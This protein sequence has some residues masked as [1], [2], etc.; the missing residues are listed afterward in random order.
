MK[1][2]LKKAV[3]LF[4]CMVFLLTVF[5]ACNNSSGDTETTVQ[6]D[7]PN[8]PVQV[9]SA[10]LSDYLIIYPENE[11]ST[12]LIEQIGNLKKLIQERYGVS[13][14]V[15]DDFV[16]EGS[17]YTVNAHEILIG[18]TNREESQAVCAEIKKAAD[19]E[20]RLCGE[21]PVIAGIT[22]GST[23]AAVKKFIEIIQNA[24]DSADVFFDGT[25][26]VSYVGTYELDDLTVGGASIAEY[27]IVYENNNG[28]KK[29]ANQIAEAVLDRTGYVLTMQSSVKAIPEGKNILVGKTTAPLPSDLTNADSEEQYYIGSENG[30]LYLYGTTSSTVYHAVKTLLD[31]IDA[32]KNTASTVTLSNGVT[33]DVDTSF[34]SMSFNV[35]YDT[36]D[37]ARIQNVI[38]TIKKHMPDTFGVQEATTTW[39]ATLKAALKDTY[40]C[41]G[42]GRVGNGGINDEYSAVFYRKDKFTLIESGTRWLSDTPTVKGSKMEGASYPRVFTYAVLET[43]DTHQRIIHVNTHT[44]HVPD[45]SVDGDAIRLAQVKVITDFLKANYPELPTIISGDM[46]NIE[47]TPAIQHLLSSGYENSSKVALDGDSTYTFKQTVIDF[48]LVSEGDFFVY[49]YKVDAEKFN[50]EYASDHR[51][52][53]IRYELTA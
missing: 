22:N 3:S 15:R 7:E 45:T 11:G 13:L 46:N 43:L 10:S 20:I 28:C 1:N 21:K 2:T 33:V 25:Q 27:S 6:T 24:N 35:L 36:S 29:L 44:D 34:T 38:S 19:Y 41:V 12:E 8:T 47:N 49:Q 40:E 37:P 17:K 50:G 30:D 16:R 9:L 14:E 4:L 23:V 31:A 42:E 53:I 51:A 5:T 52:I 32:A 48:L 18:D 26:A 39:M